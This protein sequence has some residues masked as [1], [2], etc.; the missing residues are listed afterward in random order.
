VN[1]VEPCVI[2]IF[3]V[4]CATSPPVWQVPAVPTTGKTFNKGRPLIQVDKGY[5]L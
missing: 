5:G 3:A 2:H 4:S 1:K